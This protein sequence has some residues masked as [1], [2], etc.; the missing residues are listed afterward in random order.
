M[1]SLKYLLTVQHLNWG[2]YG[3][4]MYVIIWLAKMDNFILLNQF[5]AFG[6]NLNA[7]NVYGM[8]HFDI[9]V[10]VWLLAYL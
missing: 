7:K 3:S 8:T 2:R 5:K 1:H 4:K 9:L 10:Y 6:I